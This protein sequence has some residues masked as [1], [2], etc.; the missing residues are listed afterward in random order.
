MMDAPHQLFRTYKERSHI[1]RVCGIPVTVQSANV[2]RCSLPITS[3]F[4]HSA[5]FNGPY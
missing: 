4:N 5:E 3:I 2:R 1:V